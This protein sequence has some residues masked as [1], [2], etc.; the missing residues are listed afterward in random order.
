MKVLKKGKEK[1]KVFKKTCK[2]CDTILECTKK[3]IIYDRDGSY[4]KCP[5]C[6]KFIGID[7]PSN[8]DRSKEC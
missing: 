1:V 3:D 8:P 7:I 4:V 5:I 2:T 6:K